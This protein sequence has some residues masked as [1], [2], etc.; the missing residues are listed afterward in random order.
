MG[1]RSEATGR[2][3]SIREVRIVQVGIEAGGTDAAE[4]TIWYNAVSFLAIF[5]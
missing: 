5:V 1:R 2:G 3:S 4:A